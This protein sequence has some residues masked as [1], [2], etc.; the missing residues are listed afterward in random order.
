MEEDEE[1]E[2]VE[3]AGGGKKEEGAQE[4]AEEEDAWSK[5]GRGVATTRGEVLRGRRRARGAG[6]AL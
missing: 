2:A 5:R 6:Q 1:K 3:E 4:E